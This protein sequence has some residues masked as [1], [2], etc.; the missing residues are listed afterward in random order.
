MN[1]ELEEFE[2]DLDKALGMKPKNKTPSKIV[3]PVKIA[4]V[5]LKETDD[6]ANEKKKLNIIGRIA[7]TFSII[8]I[9]LCGLKIIWCWPVW[10]VS[11]FFWIYWATK[12]KVWSQV[13]LWVAFLMLNVF[14][15]YMWLVM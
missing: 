8:G 1:N 15:W 10:I 6:E 14:S 9:V 13:I 12:K 4:N 5:P 7:T 11:N 3:E 2:K